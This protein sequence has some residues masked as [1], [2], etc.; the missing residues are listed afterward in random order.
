VDEYESEAARMTKEQNE[1]L[2]LSFES[3]AR[4]LEGLNETAKQAGKRYWPAPG[5]QREAVLSHVPNEEDEARRNL[6]ISDGPIEDWYTLTPAEDE[7]IGERSAQWAKDHP[8]E[9]KVIDA[10]PETT[11]KR[12]KGRASTQETKSKS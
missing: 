6:G 3:I 12:P 4:S 11:S 5:Q 8:P 1:R 2:V 10:R 9:A 7:P